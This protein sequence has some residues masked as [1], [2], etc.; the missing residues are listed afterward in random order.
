MVVT[1]VAATQA[2]SKAQLN[3]FLDSIN[4]VHYNEQN[5]SRRLMCLEGVVLVVPLLRTLYRPQ[6][7][8]PK[9]DQFYRECLRDIAQHG[10]WGQVYQLLVGSGQLENVPSFFRQQITEKHQQ[11]LTQ[12]LFLRIHQ[13]RIL[14]LFD[15]HALDVIPLKGPWFAE[16]YFGEIGARSSSDID[17]VVRKEHLSKAIA[18]LRALGFHGPAD[19]NPIHFHC[20]M[21]RFLEESNIPLNVELH[22]GVVIERTATQDVSQLWDTASVRR[23]YTH[24]KELSVQQTFYSICLHGSN[25]KM[26]SL[27]YVL[28]VTQLIYRNGDELDYKKLA[29]QASADKTYRRVFMVLERAYSMF[30]GLDEQKPLS[31]YG[32]SRLS[33][34]S[35]RWHSPLLVLDDWH[36]RSSYLRNRIWPGKDVALWYIRHDTKSTVRNVYFA[37]YRYRLRHFIQRLTGRHADQGNR[38]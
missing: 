33:N 10:L 26:D 3:G 18:H 34:L 36:L 6:P 37:F 16:R 32:T 14:R 29:E 24:V 23:G 12:N 35:K 8:I 28:D 15:S 17:L 25:H 9:D 19:Y 21:Y 13:E 38:Y 1:I 2:Y 20:I 22:W 27:K 30:P 31:L 11:V 7:V 4:D 5:A